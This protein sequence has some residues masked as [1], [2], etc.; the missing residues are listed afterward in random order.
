MPLVPTHRSQ[1]INSEAPTA[2]ATGKR[3]ENF[4]FIALTS[5]ADIR[6]KITIKMTFIVKNESM[7]LLPVVR[8]LNNQFPTPIIGGYSNDAV[9]DW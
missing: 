7:A 5:K 4:G 8:K 2:G 1:L 3:Y 9:A 6:K